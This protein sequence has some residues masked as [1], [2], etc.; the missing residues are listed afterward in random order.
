MKIRDEVTHMEKFNHLEEKLKRRLKPY[1]PSPEFV[2]G[3]KRK[4]TD[5]PSIEMEYPRTKAEVYIA[6][7]AVVSTA[8]FIMILIRKL[9]QK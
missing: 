8:A 3:L 2:S 7:A 1:Q 4:F 5:M 6:A 9:T